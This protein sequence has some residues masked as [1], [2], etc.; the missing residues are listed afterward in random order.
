LIFVL[1]LVASLFELQRDYIKQ[2]I[3][4][5]YQQ[6][7][8]DIYHKLC[9]QLLDFHPK[10][11]VWLVSSS[12]KTKLAEDNQANHFERIHIPDRN[13]HRSETNGNML[14]SRLFLHNG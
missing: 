8:E 11:N 12:Q 4:H 14:F 1:L 9:L 5:F 10:S 3:F 2:Q 13:P 7:Y 6:N